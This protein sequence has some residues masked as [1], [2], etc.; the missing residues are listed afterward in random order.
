M[1][2]GLGLGLRERRKGTVNKLNIKG[3]DVEVGVKHSRTLWSLSPMSSAAFCLWN[4]SQRISLI[5]EVRKCRNEGKQSK[6]TK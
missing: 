2:I 6:K 5:R 4:I 1:K 3:E